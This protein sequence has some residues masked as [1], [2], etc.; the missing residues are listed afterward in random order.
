[1][2]NATETIT[3]TDND[4]PTLD[5]DD[6][7]D[8]GTTGDA[9]TFNI[10]VS[11]NIA[12]DSVNVT[13][14]HGGL[15]DDQSLTD[16]GDGT[17]SLTI[18]LDDSLGDLTYSIQ[19]NDTSGNFVRN[20]TE[21]ITVTDNDL[22]TFDSDNSLDAG[23]TGDTYTFDITVSDNIAVDS[24]NVTWAHG[25]LG[26][27]DALVDD[28]DG[29]WS[30]TITLD[31]SL[32]DL[33]YSIQVNDT[34]GNFVRNAT[35]TITVTDNDDPV[36]E[37]NSGALWG[38][39]GDQ[40]QFS[41]QVIDN[42]DVDTV[43]VHYTHG[44][45]SEN[46]SLTDIGGNWV[47]FITLN[48]SV[49]NMV[50]SVYANDTSNNFAIWLN[51]QTIVYDNDHPEFVTDN[52]TGTPTTD[53]QF[54]FNVSATDNIGV[55]SVTLRY[56]FD[57][58]N[59]LTASMTLN[60]WDY[61]V[62]VNII[63]SAVSVKYWF[64]ITDD[65]G[66]WTEEA[67][68]Q[69][70]VEDTIPPEWQDNTDGRE[71]VAGELFTL[72]I[73]A[74]DNVAT[75]STL[76]AKAYYSFN[77]MSFSS[78]NMVKTAGTDF[79]N[80]TI[81]APD[82]AST[83]RYYFEVD[84]GSGNVVDT[85]EDTVEGQE[86]AVVL[87]TQVPEI[88][89][90]FNATIDQNE[91]MTFN[92]TMSLDNVGIV[93]YTWTFTY[94]GVEQEIYGVTVNFT[95][96]KAGVY[97]VWLNITDAQGN[98]NVTNITVT[99]KDITDPMGVGEADDDTVDQ[100]AMVTFNGSGSSDNLD[101]TEDLNYTWTFDNKDK[102]G[103]EVNFTFPDAG[104]FKVFLLVTDAAGNSNETNLTI[105]VA[106]TM[107]PMADAGDDVS[108]NI[109]AQVF[110][111]GSGSSDNVGVVSYTWT[112]K[113][114]GAT[115]TLT[116]ETDANFTFEIPGAYPITLEVADA[117]GN[118]AT[119]TFTL[120]ILD[121]IDPVANATVDT[122]FIADGAT[123]KIENI[124][125]KVGKKVDFDA[126]DSTDNVAIANWTWTITK[127]SDVVH[128]YEGETTSYTFME[129]GT[130][131]VTLLVEDA[132]GNPNEIE[133]TV[134]VTEKEDTT[135][136]GGISNGAKIGIGIGVVV[137]IIVIILLV[138]VFKK[139]PE[140]EEE[141]EEEEYGEEELEEEEMVEAGLVEE[142]LV[143]EA[144]A[145]EVVEFQCPE[146]G[147]MV[148]ETDSECPGCGVVFEEG[149]VEEEIEVVQFECPECGSLV[150][151]T[152]AAC[153]GCGVEFEAE[154]YEEDVLE[155]VEDLEAELGELEME[156]TVEEGEGLE[157]IGEE[158]VGEDVDVAVEEIG[159]GLEAAEGE[160]V[161][162][163]EVGEGEEVVEE[164]AGEE[165]FGEE[166]A[167]AE[168]EVVEEAYEEAAEEAT[169]EEVEEV[170]EEV[171]EEAGEEYGEEVVEAAEEE[172]IE[173]EVE[174]VAEETAE[175]DLSLGD[176][177]EDL[178]DDFDA[179]LEGLEDEL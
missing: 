52:T 73:I 4:D 95:F 66:N 170:S 26:N 110:F 86:P 74:T 35:E 69:I 46:V 37:M 153:P 163:E 89:A 82:N 84:D 172:V 43:F 53:G 17:W 146:C 135:T 152:D 27:N 40:Y 168:E 87:D 34:S 151:E 139:K 75:R 140:E 121:N 108:K 41:I 11:D 80:L 100:G 160:E 64:N 148:A 106:D 159:E 25:G 143:E 112:F 117:A 8:A 3:V 115:K 118:K 169:E 42:I 93:N 45:Y 142:G 16:D 32:G 124:D 109:G 71:P 77:N 7:P 90:G 24:V 91:N 33:T 123:H 102:Y 12:V 173:E 138:V 50:Y 51:N 98:W 23:T 130:Y 145:E 127:G 31:D 105:T 13:W 134:T 158:V 94:D 116:G 54:M 83:F 60:G 107:L 111:D 171:V 165:E 55:A 99:V 76:S 14:T 144:E 155:D 128:T 157:D 176:E 101:A 125:P 179:L 79:Y 154:E 175:D 56:T 10:T 22:P 85:Y 1:M 49:D 21:T 97:L 147:Y 156:E 29:T 133:F 48:H 164:E 63:E 6:S 47:A 30:L 120:T 67:G 122:V 114:G 96:D 92:A 59:F 119:A 15:G 39:T 20:A 68:G 38:T 178:D 177:E 9:Y 70:G 104:V 5:H 103:E 2:R 129:G 18:T 81:L 62:T 65:A 36:L 150:N 161:V 126:K 131:T 174:E 136:S 44:L 88:H 166:V 78:G 132:A 149:E 113:Y 167:E 57:D 141:E 61:Q 58:V 162:E 137:L 19:V 28:G 72:S